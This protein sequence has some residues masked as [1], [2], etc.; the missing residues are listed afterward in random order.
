MSAVALSDASALFCTEAEE[1]EEE[2]VC[3]K[4]EKEADG[5]QCYII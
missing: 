1:E 4:L 3:F 5:K 2:E